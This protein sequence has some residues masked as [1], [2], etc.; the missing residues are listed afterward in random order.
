MFLI[1]TFRIKDVGVTCK[2]IY[3]EDEKI[4]LKSI[5]NKYE[6]MVYPAED[7]H[8]IGKVILEEKKKP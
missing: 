8:I 5:N 7:I 4:R 2:R 6:D 3:R 1:L